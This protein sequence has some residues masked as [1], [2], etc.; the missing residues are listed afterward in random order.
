MKTPFHMIIV[1][2]KAC[3]KTHYLL[4]ML[5]EEYKNNFDYIFIVCPTLQDNKTYQNWIPSIC[6]IATTSRFTFKYFRGFTSTSPSSK[7]V[8]PKLPLQYL[9]KRLLYHVLG[10][11]T[12]VSRTRCLVGGPYIS[13]LCFSMSWL[14]RCCYLGPMAL[15]RCR[16][17]HSFGYPRKST[18]LSRPLTS[19]CLGRFANLHIL[20]VQ[21]LSRTLYA[22]HL[23]QIIST[24]L[25]YVN[26][27]EQDGIFAQ[28]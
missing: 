9:D 6:N 12:R 3:G 20:I 25:G 18:S 14:C 13:V 2:M 17:Y 11:R 10:S 24:V 4:E 5:E 16:T 23:P 28:T 7:T 19:Y 26:H 21:D 1:G 22:F 15:C 27:G 8:V